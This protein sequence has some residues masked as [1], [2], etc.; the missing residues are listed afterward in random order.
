MGLSTLQAPPVAGLPGAASY[1]GRRPPGSTVDRP[2]RRSSASACGVA[3]QQ[4]TDFRPPGPCRNSTATGHARP[5]QPRQSAR[6]TDRRSAPA[7]AASTGSRSPA[8]SPSVVGVPA[9]SG[10]P[11]PSSLEVRACSFSTDGNVHLRATVGEGDRVADLLLRK[12]ERYQ[13]AGLPGGGDESTAARLG[14]F[15]G[16][17]GVNGD[18]TGFKVGT[19]RHR[20]ARAAA[21]ARRLAARPIGSRRRWSRSPSSAPSAKRTGSAAS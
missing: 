6:D 5:A 13:A 15:S 12:Q 16:G 18:L 11:L 20:A 3:N 19:R 21:L 9:S 17:S 8:R 7:A 4:Q 10:T 14:V 2:T 1:C